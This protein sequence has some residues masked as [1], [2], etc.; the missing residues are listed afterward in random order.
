MA[1]GRWT[2][3]LLLVLALAGVVRAESP[4]VRYVKAEDPDDGDRDFSIADR[5]TIRFS[6]EEQEAPKRTG[7]SHGL[8][9]RF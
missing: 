6:P 2:V 7:G 4:D 1:L 8:A 5:L 3:T 9:A